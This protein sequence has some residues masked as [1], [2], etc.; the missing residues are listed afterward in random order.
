FSCGFVN[1]ARQQGVERGVGR[2]NGREHTGLAGATRAFSCTA[3]APQT[4]TMKTRAAL[5]PRAPMKAVVFECF[6]EP[7]EVLAMREVP[8]P[9][10]GPGQVRV[11]MLASPLNPSDLLVVRG[12]YGRVP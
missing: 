2:Y 1:V 4:R 11:R 7:R 9:E 6:G 10:P 12:Q 3:V 5:Q 8:T